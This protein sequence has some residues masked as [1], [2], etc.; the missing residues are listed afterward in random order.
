[1]ITVT[2]R[3][4]RSKSSPN[5]FPG[6]SLSGITFWKGW[7]K[8]LKKVSYLLVGLLLLAG[9]FGALYRADAAAKGVSSPAATK[10][11]YQAPAKTDD[12]WSKL[13][14]EM[15]QQCHRGAGERATQQMLKNCP[16]YN[17]QNQKNGQN[18][19]EGDRALQYSGGMMQDPAMLELHRQHHGEVSP[20]KI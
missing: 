5:N 18:L 8:M 6:W 1:M 17:G 20:A 11:G 16:Y 12:D 13:H 9:V 4:W 3:G 10:V 15:L 19:K 7:R 14:Q 2:A